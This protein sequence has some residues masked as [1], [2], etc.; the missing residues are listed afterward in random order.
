ML[1]P[2]TAR[3]AMRP[4]SWLLWAS[5]TA[6]WFAASLFACLNAF[7][8][9]VSSVGLDAP[10][11]V[12]ALLKQ[13]V[14]LL[15]MDASAI[16]DAGPDRSALVRRARREAVALLATEGYF[17]P[18]IRIARTDAAHWRLI[19]EPGQRVTVSAVDI[20]FQGG[21]GETNER[22]Q[23]IFFEQLR[24]GWSL[25]PGTPFRQADWESAKQALLDA[26]RDERYAAA[27]FVSS[28]AEIDADAAQATIRIVADTGPTF[29]LGGLKISG[30]RELPDDFIA[31]YNTLKE[32]AVY[33][34]SD[35]LA[36]QESLQSAAQLSV[37]VVS[38]DP[39][40]QQ[41]SAVPVQV[42]VT[43]APPR[44]VGFGLGASSNT[45]FR[46]ESTYRHLNLFKKGWELAGGLR[47]EQ[48]RQ[49]LFADLFLPPTQSRHHHRDSFGVGLDRSDL[50][51][52][53]IFTQAA[54]VS[55]TTRRGHIETQMSARVQHEEIEPED[56]EK[57]SYSTFTLNMGRIWRAVDNV[58]NPRR[59]HV[60]EVQLGGGMGLSPQ[61]SDFARAYGRIQQYFPLSKDNVLSLRF[62]GGYT[63]ADTRDGVPQDFL[64]RAGGT[65]SVRGYAYRSLGVEEGSATVGGRVL[66]TGSVELVHWL[67]PSTGLAVFVDSGDAADT[68]GDFSARTG[69][70]LGMRWLSPAGPLA[71]DLAWGQKEKKPRL[72]F[73]VSVAF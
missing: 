61:A 43:E 46:V 12:R 57:S 40:P 19:V 37:V 28:K 35:L 5:R 33:R 71:V 4:E 3:H 50:E 32:G 10:Q 62:E 31:R 55:R 59:G 39:D 16:P 27:K 63:F 65:Q 18:D 13:Y 36:F 20:Q 51:G 6:A 15:R 24:Q 67:K 49:S 48:R 21:D 53:K 64:F 1:H 44:R 73:G 70:G 9:E 22:E 14:H 11:E 38:I 41:A 26:L 42:A 56:A 8:G 54:G 60:L 17:S 23:K 45:G 68:A 47:L 58:L 72:H 25:P 69:Y 7:A 2:E 52:L 30:L 34:R 29:R 66:A